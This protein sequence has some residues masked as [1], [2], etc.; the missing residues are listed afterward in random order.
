MKS[1]SLASPRC[2]SVESPQIAS[3]RGLVAHRLHNSTGRSEQLRIAFVHNHRITERIRPAVIA[4]ATFELIIWFEPT[5]PH[6]D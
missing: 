5:V 2:R 3:N 6:L 1:K 4:F